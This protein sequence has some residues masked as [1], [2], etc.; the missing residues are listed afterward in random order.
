MSCQ[1]IAVPQQSPDREGDVSMHIPRG[2]H[3]HPH[4]ARQS[5]HTQG[6]IACG[7]SHAGTHGASSQVRLCCSKG[8]FQ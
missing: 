6:H 3:M 4:A 2:S 1:Q 5:W 8:P 7:S